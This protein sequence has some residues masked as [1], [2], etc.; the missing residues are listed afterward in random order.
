MN[1]HIDRIQRSFTAADGDKLTIDETAIPVEIDKD[2][3]RR[4][5]LDSMRA[6]PE[7]QSYFEQHLDNTDMLLSLIEIALED[8]PDSIR[9][10]ASNRISQFSGDLLRDYEDSLLQLQ[11]EKWESI[12]DGATVALAKI[13]SMKG[14]QYF[15]E[16]RIEPTLSWEARM[17]RNFLGDF[18]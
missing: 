3:V 2:K 8:E 16:N 7:A 5:L 1:T 12:S 13:R 10:Q 11:S 9:L 4:L 15:I 17:L 6:L 14:L 18:N